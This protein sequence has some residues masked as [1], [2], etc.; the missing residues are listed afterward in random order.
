MTLNVANCAHILARARLRSLSRVC[1]LTEAIRLRG[2]HAT[3]P[4][5]EAADL[6]AEDVGACKRVILNRPH[7]LNALNLGMLR[8]IAHNY[9]DCKRKSDRV[10]IIKGSGN[11]AFCAGGDIRALYAAGKC[12]DWD[13]LPRTFFREEF[14]LNYL[15]RS[16]VFPHVAILDGIVMGGGVGLSVHGQYRICTEN[17]LF[18]MPETAIGFFVDVG[19]SLFLSRLGP[20]G[21]YLALTGARLKGAQLV[22]AGI[23]THFI[24]S[25]KLPEVESRLANTPPE[26]VDR[27]L[28]NYVAPYDVAGS[29]MIRRRRVIDKCF[30]KSSVEEISEALER[31]ITDEAMEESRVWCRKTLDTLNYM[32]PTSLKVSH[33]QLMTGPQLDY[34]ACFKMEFRIAWTFMKQDSDFLEGVRAAVIDK[35]RKP[36]WS[37]ARLVDVS[38]EQVDAYFAQIGSHELHLPK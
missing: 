24:P 21:M 29:D 27:L 26:L 16:R 19:G 3:P 30:D 35:D 34:A 38:K 25:A 31:A 2:F 37:P 22:E 8:R 5:L 9:E 23:A 36:N 20:L 12:G 28:K 33:R 6:L 15:I 18:A 10:V 4:C 17:A 1:P 32:S 14:Q 13:G 7:A 11:K